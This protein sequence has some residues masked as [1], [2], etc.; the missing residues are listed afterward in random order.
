MVGPILCFP[1][2]QRS[3]SGNFPLL[4]LSGWRW[5]LLLMELTEL[6]Q[7]WQLSSPAPRAPCHLLAV[8]ATQAGWTSIIANLY[9]VFA[10]ACQVLGW[11]PRQHLHPYLSSRPANLPLPE[12][13][14]VL[15]ISHRPQRL[16]SQCIYKEHWEYLCIQN[17]FSRSK[18]RRIT[19]MK[20]LDFSC[21]LS[22]ESTAT[23]LSRK[24]GS[25][26]LFQVGIIM[27][28]MLCK[29]EAIH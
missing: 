19:L 16:F 24:A 29:S 6:N 28:Q 12:K 10:C 27:V 25:C 13:G 4:L 15:D 8:G 1:Y 5:M 3:S 7:L 11:C 26:A 20:L 21:T 2:P 22:P 23:S 9:S 17:F 14:N 18:M